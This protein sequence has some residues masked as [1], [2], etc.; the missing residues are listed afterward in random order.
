MITII[1]EAH[2]TTLDNEAGLASGWNNV[3]LSPLGEQ[4][5]REMGERYKN[6]RFDAVFTSDLQ[7]ATKSAELAFGSRQWPIIQDRRLRECDYGD[8]AGGPNEI[9]EAQKSAHLT[10]PFP[11][12]E[13]Y[14]QTTERMRSFLNDLLRDR[15]GQ[16]IMIIGHRATQYGLEHLLNGAPM[17]ALVTVRFKWQP[18]WEYRLSIPEFGTS[19]ADEQRRDGGCG[20]VFDPHTQRYAVGKDDDGGRFRLFSGGVEPGEAMQAGILREVTE[21]SGLDDFLYVEKIGEALAHYH[22]SLKNLN[23]VAHAHCFLVILKSAHAVPVQHEAHEKFSLTWATTGEIFDNWK[24][25]NE[26]HGIDHWIYFFQ[27]S[28]A[29]AIELGYDTTTKTK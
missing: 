15:D 12:G 17:E 19:R 2:G 23:R 1:F 25:W 20:V 11:N 22:N 16:R 3:A 5:S 9:V 4:Q 14:A 8:L 28:V 13:S 26:D 21:E 18:G 10:E 29:R 6:D 7:R 24:L 27:K